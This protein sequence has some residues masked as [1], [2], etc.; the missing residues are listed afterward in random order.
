MLYRNIKHEAVY[1]LERQKRPAAIRQPGATQRNT[2][3]RNT[4]RI[5]RVFFV[6]GDGSRPG[7]APCVSDLARQ[8]RHHSDRLAGIFTPFRRRDK[9]GSRCPVIQFKCIIAQDMTYCNG[10]NEH[11]CIG[12]RGPV[13]AP[14]SRCVPSQEHRQVKIAPGIFDRFGPIFDAP[15]SGQEKGIGAFRANAYSQQPAVRAAAR[16]CGFWK[17]TLFSRFPE[18][19]DAKFEKSRRRAP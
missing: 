1:S 12:R 9:P 7:A 10:E 14:V 15:K 8:S 2:T 17:L 19:F 4:I 18:R 11:L 3:Q 5:P 6:P 13:F 16:V